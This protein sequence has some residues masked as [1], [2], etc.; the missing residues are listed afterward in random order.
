MFT[1]TP[2]FGLAQDNAT[3]TVFNYLNSQK[4]SDRWN[5]RTLRHASNNVLSRD[6]IRELDNL[7]IGVTQE[8]LRVTQLIESSGLV[9]NLNNPLAKLRIEWQTSSDSGPA[10]MAMIPQSQFESDRILYGTDS[11]PLPIWHRGI[12]IDV[13][14]AAQDQASSG[15]SHVSSQVAAST[16]AIARGIEYSIFHGSRVYGSNVAVPGLLTYDKRIEFVLDTYLASDNPNSPTTGT[17]EG[18]YNPSWADPRTTGKQIIDTLNRMIEALQNNGQDRGQIGYNGPYWLFL[19]ANMATRLNEPFLF[20]ETAA[21]MSSETILDR[22]QSLPQISGVIFT[23]VLNNMD[24]VYGTGPGF[25]V[26]KQT[27]TDGTEAAQALQNAAYGSGHNILLIQPTREVLD[28]VNGFAPTLVNW[29]AYGG[30]E[31]N[32]MVMAMKSLRLKSNYYGDT[33]ILHAHA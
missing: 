30:L 20:S 18:T 25:S 16:R 26:T 12:K 11:I 7:I 13:R 23:P 24:M 33:G 8:E 21:V 28:L 32:W 22:I 17:S 9:Y 2:T 29:N 31:Q 3:Q 14:Q 10:T 5:L 27:K 19:P 15:E 1:E 4:D 6:A